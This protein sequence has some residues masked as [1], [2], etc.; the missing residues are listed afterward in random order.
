MTYF[1]ARQAPLIVALAYVFVANASASVQTKPGSIV[2]PNNAE[3]RHL[4]IEGEK[5]STF[6]PTQTTYQSPASTGA[7]PQ[8]GGTTTIIYEGE[9]VSQVRTWFIP[10]ATVDGEH[11]AAVRQTGA[12]GGLS[13]F[14]G[15]QILTNGSDVSCYASG[16]ANVVSLDPCEE[17]FN[18][19]LEYSSSFGALEAAGSFTLAETCSVYAYRK[20]DSV[21]IRNKRGALIASLP[22]SGVRKGGLATKFA[23]NNI[24][25]PRIYI[26]VPNEDRI[27]VYSIAN[28]DAEACES[29]DQGFNNFA[30]ATILQGPPGSEFGASI[31]SGGS[32]VGAP[33]FHQHRG[34]V[35]FVNESQT[36][37]KWTAY[38]SSRVPPGARMSRVAGVGSSFLRLAVGESGVLGYL[39]RILPFNFPAGSWAPLYNFN[40]RLNYVDTIIFSAAGRDFLAIGAPDY[41]GHGT[42]FAMEIIASG[43]AGVQP[44]LNLAAQIPSPSRIDGER[45]GESIYAGPHGIFVLAP[46]SRRGYVQINPDYPRF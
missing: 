25:E 14:F 34:A 3:R 31:D 11:F 24:N 9:G 46:G 4:T 23:N 5:D 1:T 39:S 41:Q 7:G 38:Y 26:G 33:A 42:V 43:T 36:Y 28:Q 20:H 10:T 44:D 16:L 37:D 21:D 15:F 12:S 22:H 27:Y 30:Q 35:F 17:D 45:Y 2:G 29:G 40:T 19:E 18:F 32:L 8:Q 6:L 13:S